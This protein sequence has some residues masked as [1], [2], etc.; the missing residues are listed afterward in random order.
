MA[1]AGGVA[2]TV[3]LTNT[4]TVATE[5]GTQ[6]QTSSAPPALTLRLR[7]PRRVRF[8]ASAVDN[9]HLG[10]KKS[11]SCCIYHRRKAFDESSDESDAECQDCA[12][13]RE[14]SGGGTMGTMNGPS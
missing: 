14:L 6:A 11:K 4:S 1:D 9:E 2:Q 10:R 3:E 12:L 13:P 8:D 5:Q 7:A